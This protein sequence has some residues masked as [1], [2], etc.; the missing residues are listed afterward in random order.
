M[1]DWIVGGPPYFGSQLEAIEKTSQFSWKWW[2]K[3]VAKAD[4]NYVVSYS[5]NLLF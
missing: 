5:E 3:P 4:Y 2:P 1:D